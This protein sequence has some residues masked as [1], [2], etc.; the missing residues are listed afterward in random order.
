MTGTRCLAAVLCAA[1]LV[2]AGVAWAAPDRTERGPS[3]VTPGSQDGKAGF[4]V[5]YHVFTL[6]DYSAELNGLLSW[7]G[8]AISLNGVPTTDSTSG[9]SYDNKTLEFGKKI[10]FAAIDEVLD[11]PSYVGANGNK[12]NWI[13]DYAKETANGFKISDMGCT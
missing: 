1:S 13:R 7:T 3:T 11:N 10:D 6:R 5:E 8:R 9:A 4:W 2:A 12:R